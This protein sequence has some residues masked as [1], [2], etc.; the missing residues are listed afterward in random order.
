MYRSAV[1]H[2]CRRP[3]DSKHVLV[4]PVVVSPALLFQDRER[5]KVELGR[6]GRDSID[7]ICIVVDG[8]ERSQ[9]VEPATALGDSRSSSGR[10]S[11]RDLEE[12]SR[13]SP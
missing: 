7:R 12:G 4:N 2:S 5:A 3:L 1:W 10:E 8:L 13:P 6:V 9:D 11:R